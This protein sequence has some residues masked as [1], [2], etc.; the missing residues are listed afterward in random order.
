M[1][2]YREVIEKDK[3]VRTGVLLFFYAGNEPGAGGKVIA[4]EKIRQNRYENYTDP[5]EECADTA[6]GDC[7][8]GVFVIAVRLGA[9]RENGTGRRDHRICGEGESAVSELSY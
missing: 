3:G 2:I 4:Y 5:S 7:G 1:H 9:Y 6:Q 8:A